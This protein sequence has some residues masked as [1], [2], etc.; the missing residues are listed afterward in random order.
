MANTI[1]MKRS[2]QPD[3]SKVSK[4]D[5]ARLAAYVDGEGCIDISVGG[6][7]GRG[8]RKPQHLR[9]FVCNTDPR[10]I[11]WCQ[12][13][14]GGTVRGKPRED[15]KRHRP[16]WQ[17][18]V[19]ANAAKDILERCLPYFII[20]REQAELGLAFQA[21]KVYGQRHVGLAKN[22][23]TVPDT[24]LEYRDHCYEELR[25]LK[26]QIHPESAAIN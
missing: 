11:M 5:W 26:H 23:R 24:V 8:Y 25:R 10:L 22:A 15:R 7:N 4:I 9:T 6:G 2:F 12:R 14:F 17:W 16:C 1:A 18:T 19:S 3:L 20:K 13:T 21:T